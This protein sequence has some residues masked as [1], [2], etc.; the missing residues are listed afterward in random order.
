MVK[1]TWLPGLGLMWT[2]LALL[3]L[4]MAVMLR[5]EPAP[6]ALPPSVPSG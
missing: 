1:V 6:R 2:A 3:V 4:S 5:A